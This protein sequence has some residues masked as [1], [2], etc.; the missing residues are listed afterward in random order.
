MPQ[1]WCERPP[2]VVCAVHG[3]GTTIGKGFQGVMKR[4][5]F[6]GQPASH[7]NSLAHRA[8]GSIGACQD[9]G[10]VW[11]G[12]KMPGRMGGAT[13]TLSCAFVYKVGFSKALVTAHQPVGLLVGFVSPIVR[14][15]YLAG[16]DIC[17]TSLPPPA[18]C[19]HPSGAVVLGYNSSGA[20]VHVIW[21]C[22]WA[23]LLHAPPGTPPPGHSQPQLGPAVLLQNTKTLP[24]P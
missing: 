18:P 21:V 2:H 10:K 3:T 5:G 1:I 22:H 17:Q 7:G 16:E 4:W 9:P 12:K 23:S 20:A 8:G 19:E 13:R 24:E 15:C 6:A 14:V 11:P